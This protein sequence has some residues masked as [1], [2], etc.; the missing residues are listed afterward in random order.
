[1]NQL[2][3]K[4]TLLLDE[5][6]C[7]RNIR[8][9]YNKA[10]NKSLIFR[11]HFKTHQS[12]E[13]GSWYKELGVN[14]ITVSSLEMADYFSSQ[15]ND[16]TVAFPVNIL[17]I[18]LINSLA[19]RIQLNLMV[20]SIEAAIFLMSH[21]QYN[22]GVFIKIDV[23]YKRVGIDPSNREEID[24]IITLLESSDKIIFKG[25]LAHA[26]HT[27][28]CRSKQEIL[29]VHKKSVE[30][31]RNLKDQYQ[32]RYPH[33]INSY[34]DTPSCSVAEDFE[35]IDE[36]RPG[37][38]VFYDLAQ[39]QIGSTDIS[40][41]A[42]AMV[43][44]IVSMNKHRNE[45]VIYGGGVHFSKDN[46]QDEVYGKIYGKVVNKNEIGWKDEL[47]G[48]YLKKLSQEHGIVS[49]P[50]HLINDYSIGDTLVIL[51]VHSCMT[52]NEMKSYLLEPNKEITRL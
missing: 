2:I 30:I 12:L 25:F 15:W 42:V 11:P 10:V 3:I 39:V 46:L 51:P 4:P 41:I 28:D 31:L 18:E 44:P 40:N 16:I 22:I 17:E 37:N 52:G 24:A 48:A 35:G 13:I 33:I 50:E 19:K 7:R 5:K 9:V 8:K 27:Y 43:C 26:G 36:I 49:M 21:L 1:M 6:K 20:E 34:G 14:K 29:R 32:L 23:G 47:T 45:I 38:F